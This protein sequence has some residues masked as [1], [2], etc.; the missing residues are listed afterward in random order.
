MIFTK[1]TTTSSVK[2]NLQTV[3]V[4]DLNKRHNVIFPLKF[5]IFNY[6]LNASST[7]FNT[8]KNI[9][10]FT[11]FVYFLSSCWVRSHNVPV[12]KLDVTAFRDD[13][14]KKTYTVIAVLTFFHV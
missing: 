11:L 5:I 3:S 2:V 12:Y 8:I 14:A 10:N 4:G 13:S 1:M 7:A 6:F 9:F